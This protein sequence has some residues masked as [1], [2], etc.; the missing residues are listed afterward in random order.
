MTIPLANQ[1]GT[2]RYNAAELAKPTNV[3]EVVAL[4]RRAAE[5]GL[6]VKPFG[7][8]HSFNAIIGTGGIA[9]DL[10]A[11][12][13]VLAIDLDNATMEVEG[14]MTICDIIEA[15][16]LAGLHF[17][18]L[19]SWHSQS[20][21]GAIATSTHGSSMTWGSLSDLVLAVE[22]VLADGSVVRY[23]SGEELRA[24]RCNLGHLGIVTKVKLQ[25][26]P[27]F[28][29]HCSHETLPDEQGFAEIAERSKAAEY[30]NML[31]LPYLE[32]AAIRT[33]NRTDV[34]KRNQASIDL[35]EAFTGKTRFGHTV[36]DLRNYLLGHTVLRAPK[37][38]IPNY[39]PVICF[40]VAGMV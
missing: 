17:P 7:G 30:V 22:A 24:F 27:A 16:D 6:R 32:T 25:L 21:A 33:L 2:F 11:M 35:E 19:G 31:W 13:N 20:I 29:L 23:E 5:R 37:L 38:L 28:W 3:E 10:S 1:W 26:T 12:R 34:R 40:R 36:E 14:G 8:G 39:S 9:V 18:S 15:G 4:V